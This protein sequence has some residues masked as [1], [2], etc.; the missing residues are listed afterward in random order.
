MSHKSTRQNR[1]IVYGAAALALIVGCASRQSSLLLERR[2]RG[3]L[4]EQQAG[5]RPFAP[6]LTPATQ[7]K[8]NGGIEVTATHASPQF[9]REFFSNRQVFGQH[10]GLNPYFPEQV[11]FYIK[12]VNGSDKKIRIDPAEFV[13]LDDRGNQYRVLNADYTTALA[14]AKAP[15]S[16]ATR[17]IVD[18][19]RPG[20]FGVGVPVGKLFGK[21]QRR[22]A[23]LNMSSLQGG[24]LHAGVTYDGLVAF[25]SPDANAST[26]K[27]SLT[28]IKT[29]FNAFDFP[30]TALDVAFD[31]TVERESPR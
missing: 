18:D 10:A 5:A 3:P 31:F 25:W 13:L 27:L 11:I 28:N 24:F 23:L 17:G 9:L 7:T 15:V 22:F 21:S 6:S 2:A 26:L 4:A 12:V 30:Q 16:T 19:A 29:D 8:T 14:E 20:Y 1:S